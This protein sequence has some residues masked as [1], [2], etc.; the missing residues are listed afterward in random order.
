[1]RQLRIDPLPAE[2]A[3]DLLEALLGPD[4]SLAPLKPLLIQRTEGNPL[5]LEESV[6]ALVE[7]G[8]LT[9]A[10]S[11]YRLE[12]GLD[13]VRMPATV[14]AIIAARID[15]LSPGDKRVL[16]AAAVI[17]R[18]VPLP[19]LRAVVESD[20][21]ELRHS[22]ARLQA[23]E[24]VYE[25]R[26]F[27]E[28]EYTFTHALTHE[29]AYG[30]VLQ[31]RRRALHA[32]IAEAIER[33]YAD[34]LAEQVERLAHHTVR[35]Q[36]RE[37]AARYL[38]LAGVRAAARSANRE[39]IDFFQQ[40][41]KLLEELPPTPGF[42]AEALDTRIALGPA[43]IAMRGA[44]GQEVETS[45]LSALE[46]VDRL[47]DAS[48]RFPALLGLWFVKYNRG[49]YRAA[50]EA[51]EGLLQAAQ[52]SDDT[53]RLLQAHHAFWAT[54]TIMGQPAAAMAHLE[55]GIALYDR[56]QHA[57][58]AF[59]YGG[60]DPGAC[61]RYHLALNR[62]LLGQPD[63]AL[64]ALSEAL[65]LAEELKHPLTKAIALW[66]AAWVYHQ[67]GEGEATAATIER[68]IS[69]ASAHG[70]PMWV[71]FASVL[72]HKVRGAPL[73]VETL[74][75]L[76]GRLVRARAQGGANWRHVFCLGVLAELYADAGHAEEGHQV[77]A[78]ITADDRAAFCAPEVFR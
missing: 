16:Q 29:V 56:E 32:A 39:A 14:Q 19:L 63:R 7:T 48:R 76:H 46:L 8:T 2:S 66:F 9:G 75:E 44:G 28:L 43:L 58:Q 24:L 73:T 60:H 4:P 42:L 53:G 72:L 64:S 5:F 37:K 31:D 3:V 47:G 1:Y 78:S 13:T 51:A 22:L 30:A 59:L 49:E 21:D 57:S 26:L 62:W 52:G 34:R 10:P 68:L 67:R 33:L 74:A 15:R 18:D 35:G 65:R 45:Y 77:L 54:L 11:A 41:L 12:R 70:F 17:G 71:D 69:L 50:G 6:R 55:R 25:A 40:A 38:R 20:E 61:C 23:A 27:P 36:V